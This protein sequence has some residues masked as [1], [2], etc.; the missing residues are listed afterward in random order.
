MKTEWLNQQFINLNLS[1][2][3]AANL[4]SLTL[5]T[6]V[7]IVA[8]IATVV[9]RKTVLV[10]VVRWIQS[11]KYQWDDPLVKNNFFE[12]ISWFVPLA[13]LSI[14]NDSLLFE[15][16]TIHLLATRIVLSGFVIVS[17]LSLNAMLTSIMEI[18]LLVR[19]TR[20][21]I[22]QGYTDA[23][24]II[25]YVLGIIFIISIFTGQ[26]PWGILSVLGGLT[27]V[28]ML[29]FKDSILG[30]VASLQLSSS[31]MIRIGDWIEMPQYGADGDVISISIH[32]VRVQNWDK[33]I[34]TI[35]TYALVSSSFKNWRGMTESKGRRIKRS[36]FVDLHSISFCPDQLLQELSKIEILKEYIEN[37]EREITAYNA[38]N[39]GAENSIL[40]GRRQ[41]N[42]GIF[43]AYI[44]A[45]LKRNNQIHQEMTFLVRQ[46]APTDHGLP[47]EIYVFSRDQNWV[48][49]EAIQAD[50]FDHLLAAAREF[51]LR[52]FQIPSG[53]D[54]RSISLDRQE[55]KTV[56]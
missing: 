16:D 39:P 25:T 15:H 34:T 30:F 24:K 32:T 54:L 13:V 38:D 10:A 23:F 21:T 36:L 43:R 3:T 47:I 11:N 4:S 26:S 35:P 49:Y 22:L 18:D 27:A 51:D 52:V 44:I 56:Q 6:I 28:T 45:Y 12:K 7:L 55:S 41:T 19:K 31:D 37:K 33:T 2:E 46:L 53:F 5:L 20:R 1:P 17:V 48:N 14:A 42:I 29:V 50:I 8:G 9:V 40:N